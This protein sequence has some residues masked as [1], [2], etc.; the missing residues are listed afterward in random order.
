MRKETG[1]VT[2]DDKFFSKDQWAE[3]KEHQLCVDLR[4]IVA[5]YMRE[6]AN[7]TLSIDEIVRGTVN[8][9][10]DIRDALDRFYLEDSQEESPLERAEKTAL[11]GL[12]EAAELTKGRG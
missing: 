9:V 10:S 2:S 4:A 6:T 8:N 1:Y 11:E 3:A 7:E 5:S 12:S